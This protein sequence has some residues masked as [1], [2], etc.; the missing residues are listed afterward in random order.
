MLKWWITHGQITR[1]AEI[2][3]EMMDY[4]HGQITQQAWICVEMIDYT[5]ANNQTGRDMWWKIWIIHG[6]MSKKTRICGEKDG[7]YMGKYQNRQG[8]MCW[9]NMDLHKA[10]N[11]IGKDMCCKAWITNWKIIK[12]TKI[13]VTK[14]R[15]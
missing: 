7:L 8:Y 4:T 1:Q 11:Q 6:K 3:V 2:C 14:I 5:W 15:L 9:K 12:E 10:N 13:C